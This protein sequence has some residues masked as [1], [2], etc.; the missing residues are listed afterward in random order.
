MPSPGRL[1]EEGRESPGAPESM[2][3]PPEKIKRRRLR[4]KVT[5]DEN[6]R[7]EMARQDAWLRELL[8]TFLSNDAHLRRHEILGPAD[9][10]GGQVEEQEKKL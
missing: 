9:L 5:E 4:I 3:P 8:T 10:P 2:K 7:W 1:A 6:H